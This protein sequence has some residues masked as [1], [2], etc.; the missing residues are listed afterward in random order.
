M[1]AGTDR[2]PAQEPACRSRNGRRLIA[3]LLQIGVRFDVAHA[4]V[5][6]ERDEGAYRMNRAAGGQGRHPTWHFGTVGQTRTTI[7]LIRA[8]WRDQ[9]G[10][11]MGSHLPLRDLAAAPVDELRV[12]RDDSHY[13]TIGTR[14]SF[15]H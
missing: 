4:E 11:G 3:K 7:P 10:R 1:Q 13:L 5:Y 12:S 9:P 2:N 8:T 14:Y 6:I 15:G